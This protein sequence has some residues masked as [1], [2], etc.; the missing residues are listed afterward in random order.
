MKRI[1]ILAL[2]LGYGG[3]EKCISTLANTLC[4]NYQVNVISTYKLYE[5]PS[6]PIDDRVKITYLIPDLSPSKNE[7][8]DSVKHLKFIKGFQLGITNLKV[9]YLKKK[10]MIE[11]IKNCDSD[12]IIS[13]RDIHNDWL[14]KYGDPNILKIG[15]EHN[16]HNNDKKYINK[17]IKSVSKLDYFVLVSKELEE[18][19]RQKVKCKTVYIP[20]TLDYYPKK[21]SDLEEK[22]IISVG[23]LSEE[24][25]YLDLIDVF[26]LVHQV[27]PDWKLDII[28]DGNQ[29]ENIQKKIEEYGLKD[30]IILHG[31]QN[32]EYINQLL[33]KSSVYVMCS[34]TE[35]F[36]IVLLEAFSFG[37]PCVAF[38]SARGA[39]EIISNNWDGYLIKDR[40][41]EAMAKKVCELISNPNRRIIMGANGIKKAN[42]YSMDEIRKYWI[43]IIET[44]K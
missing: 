42:Q 19:Y 44:V 35:S 14:G 34:Y 15:W 3:I 4:K 21:V 29:K 5:K 16:H 10:K 18:F 41:K 27:Y 8:I 40:N 23:R 17:I 13:T 9:L 2:H 1:T 7:F 32:K 26:S 37:I 30:F 33:Q 36:G 38:D 20:N 12:V 43:Q 22:R 25:G 6:F 31:F 24:K 11:A 39:T 28:G